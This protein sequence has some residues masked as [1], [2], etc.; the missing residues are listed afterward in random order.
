MAYLILADRSGEL[1]R[2]ELRDSVVIGRALDCDLCVRDTLLSRRHCRIE[3][4]H[5]RWIVEDL[6]SRNGTEVDGEEIT[7]YVLS[8]G[9]VIRIGRTELYF[10]AGP[11]VPPPPA[12][13]PRSNVRPS[14]PIEAMAGTVCGFQY[15]DM[16]EDSRQSGFPIPKPKPAEPVAYRRENVH[17]MVAEMASHS[18]DLILSEP[19]FQAPPKSAPPREVAARQRYLQQAK[20]FEV[21]AEPERVHYLPPLRSESPDRPNTIPAWLARTYVALAFTVGAVSL[22]IVLVRSL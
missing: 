20:A 7:R 9:D 3:P 17:A 18:W 10:F 13:A 5:D 1:D 15:F 12:A 21:D 8:D 14:D 11:F 16:E 19:E 6:L 4:F 2:H 22:G